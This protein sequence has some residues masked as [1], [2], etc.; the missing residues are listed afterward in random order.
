MTR[1]SI[2]SS[3]GALNWLNRLN[4]IARWTKIPNGQAVKSDRPFGGALKRAKTGGRTKGS[5]K[6]TATLPPMRLP[7]ELKDKI[8][9]H[10]KTSRETTPALV[11]RIMQDE[12]DGVHL[13]FRRG[14]TKDM[15]PQP[16]DDGQAAALHAIAQL[17]EELTFA[18]FEEAEPEAIEEQMKTWIEILGNV[19]AGLA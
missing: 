18:D 5:G 1:P 11:R 6:N 12:V 7:L 8:E 14:L 17:S 16:Q 10:A 15:I 4:T 13:A 9:E 3:R 19:Y 2:D